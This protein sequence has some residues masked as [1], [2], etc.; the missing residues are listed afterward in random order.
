M[1]ALFATDKAISTFLQK[2]YSDQEWMASMGMD[3]SKHVLVI[4]IILANPDRAKNIWATILS[5]N[6]SNQ[7]AEPWQLDN[8]IT[9]ALADKSVKTCAALERD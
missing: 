8:A 3:Y 7:S 1:N 9:A 4:D 5:S 6:T 2:A